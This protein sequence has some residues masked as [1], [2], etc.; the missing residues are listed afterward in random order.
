MDNSVDTLIL[1]QTYIFTPQCE[2]LVSVEDPK[3]IIQLGSNE[4]RILTMLAEHL[5]QVVTRE[6]LHEFVWHE[7]GLQVDDSSL[8]QAISR[9]RKQLQ[10]PIKSPKFIKTIPKKGYSLVCSVEQ[11]TQQLAPSEPLNMPIENVTKHC[12]PELPDK[13][14]NLWD[15][16]N[17][18]LCLVFILSLL[19]VIYLILN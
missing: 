16:T 10:D 11:T 1:A 3:H 6:Q 5:N 12:R 2:C 7:Q 19:S 17:L 4:S 8:T 18:R 13:K 14:P 15:N 9:L